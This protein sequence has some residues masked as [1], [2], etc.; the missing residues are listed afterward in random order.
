[1]IEQEM[2][3]TLELRPWHRHYKI[4]DR[5]KWENERGNAMEDP[6]NE[7]GLKSYTVYIENNTKYYCNILFFI[8]IY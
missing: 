5:V 3:G 6:Y 7:R 1:M 4:D 2:L 8:H